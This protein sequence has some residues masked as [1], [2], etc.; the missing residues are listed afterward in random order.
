MPVRLKSW[1][2]CG[3]YGLCGGNVPL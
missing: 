1:T 3:A 2:V